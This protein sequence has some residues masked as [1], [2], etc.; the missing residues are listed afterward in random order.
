[1]NAS[2]S[3]AWSLPLSRCRPKDEWDQRKLDLA[4]YVIGSVHDEPI[5]SVLV[6]AHGAFVLGVG[7]DPGNRLLDDRKRARRET[8]LQS[9]RCDVRIA[10]F[11]VVNGQSPCLRRV[12]RAT[13]LS[14]DAIG[15]ERRDGVRVRGGDDPDLPENP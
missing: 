14:D 2:L 4:V 7:G 15:R 13:C 12:D 10:A 8:E 5:A 3:E 11:L 6:G 9:K 1:M